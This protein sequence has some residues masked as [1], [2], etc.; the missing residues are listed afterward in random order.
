M[1]CLLRP[2]AFPTH[3]AGP[4]VGARNVRP[5]IL[6]L[7]V[8]FEYRPN[9]VLEFNDFKLSPG[10]RDRQTIPK[11]F[12]FSVAPARYDRGWSGG[13]SRPSPMLQEASRGQALAKPHALRPSL[14]PVSLAGTR[15]PPA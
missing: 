15:R 2:P 9:G 7:G 13:T 11:L 12:Q 6:G 3:T 4:T 10:D 14:A 1:T 5:S 8:L